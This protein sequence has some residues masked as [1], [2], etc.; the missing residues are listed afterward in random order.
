M[1][2]V[3]NAASV[4]LPVPR[5]TIHPGDELSGQNIVERR[6][7]QRTTQQFAVVPHRNEL[8][9]MIARRTLLPGQPVPVNAVAHQLLVKRGDAARLV[10]REQGLQ[11]V[12]QVEA[13]QSGSAGATVRVRNIDSGVVVIGT[14]QADGTIRA[15]N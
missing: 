8:I 14:V 10:F 13:L 9:G 1:A 6:F 4:Q 15:G 11:I 7:P 5:V 12:M 3:S 2:P